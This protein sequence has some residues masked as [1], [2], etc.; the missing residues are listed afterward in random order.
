MMQVGSDYMPLGRQLFPRSLS[1]ALGDLARQKY[2]TAKK[3]A[4]AWG[5]DP[6]TA[7]NL[8]K[9]HLSI[10]TLMKAVAVEGRDLW[11]AL[12]T[13]LTG[14]TYH[15]YEERKLQRIIEEAEY[16]RQNLVRLRERRAL[17]DARTAD[18]DGPRDRRGSGGRRDRVG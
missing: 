8:F 9:G 14:E 1:D 12:G 6:A 4:K 2:G 18:L 3:V 5:I 11:E 15:Q 10:P 13:E 16:A 17:M 7:A